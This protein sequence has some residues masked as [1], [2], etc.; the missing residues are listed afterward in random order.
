MQFIGDSI[1]LLTYVSFVLRLADCVD[2]SG[3]NIQQ[4]IEIHL[5]IQNE[6]NLHVYICRI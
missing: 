4:L 3:F 1:Q 2:E 5:N 6:Q